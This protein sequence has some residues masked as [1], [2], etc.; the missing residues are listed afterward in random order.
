MLH[1]FL[2]G[3]KLLHAAAVNNI[4]LSSQPLGAAGSIHCHVAAA[5]DRHLLGMDDGGVRVGPVSLHQIDSGQEFVGR[6]NA[7]I[8]DAGNV[9]EHGQTCA[10]ADKDR[11]K[12]LLFHQLVHGDGTANHGIGGNRNAQS[13]QPVHFLLDDGLGQTEFGDTIDQHAAGQMQRFKNRDLISLAGQITG[14]SQT[15][16]A[17]A[18]N[19]DPMAVGRRLFRRGGSMGIV[20]V[21]NKPLQPADGHRFTLFAPDAIFLALAFLRADTAADCGQCGSM[22]NDLIGLLKVALGNLGNKLR[23]MYHNRTAGHAGLRFAVQA[24]LCLIQCLL[25]RVSQRHLVK[26]FIADI[27]VLR[28]HGIL[29]QRHI[30]HDYSASFLN[31]LQVSSCLCISKSRYI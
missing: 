14:A 22:G 28:G 13:L 5:H 12:A 17:G 24:A 29:G 23:N 21:G 27:G 7:L 10:G 11:F 3:G 26:V 4:H 8:V 19:C 31:R 18:D 25:L 9:H 15:G 20:P 1:L 30:R 6:E 2:T 16:R